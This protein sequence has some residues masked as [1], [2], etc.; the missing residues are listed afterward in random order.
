MEFDI[1]LMIPDRSLSILD[2]A[3]VV[4]GWQSCTNEGS[5][6]RAILDALAREYDFSL[7]TPFEEYPEKIQDILIN[8]TNGHSVKVYYKGQRG[9]GVYDVAFPG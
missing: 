2:G 3:I 4:T 6:S 8:G 5:F 7:A 9:E 1:D